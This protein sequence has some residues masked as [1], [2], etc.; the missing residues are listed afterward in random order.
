MDGKEVYSINPKTI[1]R[2]DMLKDQSAI[3]KYGEKA[4]DGV[5]II[6]LKKS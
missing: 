6:T 5:V 1:E 3:E 4:K 2:L